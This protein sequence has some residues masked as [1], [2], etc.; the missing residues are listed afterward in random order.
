MLEISLEVSVIWIYKQVCQSFNP[1]YAGDQ[2]R[3]Y[4]AYS[5]NACLQV[6]ILIMLEISLEA[7]ILV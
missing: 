2:F 4:F 7:G 3:R 1:Y 5:A 6:S